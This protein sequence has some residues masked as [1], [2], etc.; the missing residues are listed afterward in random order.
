MAKKNIYP[1]WCCVKVHR[2]FSVWQGRMNPVSDRRSEGML[3]PDK[4]TAAPK[5]THTPQTEFAVQL[6]GS[7]ALCQAGARPDSH[8]HPPVT[9]AEVPLLTMWG[10][11]SPPPP[12][13]LTQ[14]QQQKT[15]AACTDSTQPWP[16]KAHYAAMETRALSAWQPQCYYK[17]G[18]ISKCSLK[19]EKTTSK[20]CLTNSQT[21]QLLFTWPLWQLTD[22]PLTNFQLAL[23]SV[24]SPM[25][26][27]GSFLGT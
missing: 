21:R 24:V 14:C 23:R 18:W 22:W 8:R 4:G 2:S 19:P 27:S 11:S 13:A 16:S 17:T 20:P 25:V 7:C 9:S 3:A 12:P 15:Q 1:I 10:D 6:R 5:N 26:P